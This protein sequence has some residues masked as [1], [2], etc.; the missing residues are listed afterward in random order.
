MPAFAIEQPS[1]SCHGVARPCALSGFA[2]TAIEQFMDAAA[3][4]AV[5]VRLMAAPVPSTG[6]VATS[7]SCLKAVWPLANEFA[8][9]TAA[10]VPVVLV[11]VALADALALALADAVGA[12]C[13]N[14]NA[15]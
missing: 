11:A 13:L 10:P 7:P 1:P 5:W 3:C 12:G 4:A 6:A 9:A 2:G 8:G 15:D 14:R